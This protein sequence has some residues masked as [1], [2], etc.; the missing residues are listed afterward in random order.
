ME[1][2]QS[3]PQVDNLFSC[4]QC[5]FETEIKDEFDTHVKR[6]TQE[7]FC[8]SRINKNGE[9][10]VESTTSKERKTPKRKW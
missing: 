9:T 5:D 3:L 7:N 6:R 2:K 10:A 8:S 1:K 4:N